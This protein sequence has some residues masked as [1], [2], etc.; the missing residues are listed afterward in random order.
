MIK[1]QHPGYLDSFKVEPEP[2]TPKLTD[3]ER[4]WYG[5]LQ[6]TYRDLSA[7]DNALERLYPETDP[8]GITCA[9]AK[10]EAY[11]WFQSDSKEVGSFL[12]IADLLSIPVDKAREALEDERKLS[13]ISRIQL[14]DK[15]RNI[16]SESNC[17]YC[18]TVYTKKS[19]QQRYC[20][21]ACGRRFN[22]EKYR[23][24]KGLK[25]N[26]LNSKHSH[27]KEAK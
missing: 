27:I 21:E 25:F 26:I 7:S 6:R 2:S 17:V 4:L 16:E 10:Q 24:Q 13:V 19:G 8:E 14:H 20:S 9:S 5:V 11:E 18:N 15:A 23:K 22:Y 3:E 1:D 12:Y